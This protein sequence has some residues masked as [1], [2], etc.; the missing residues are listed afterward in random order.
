LNI[1]DLFVLLVLGI[2]T[3]I[4][5]YNGSIVSAINAA[6]FVLSWL[7]SLIFYPLIS[8]LIISK[9]PSLFTLVKFYADGSSKIPN[10]ENRAMQVT[11]FTKESVGQIVTDSQIP[12]PFGRILVSAFSKSDTSLTLAEYFDTT[13][14]TVIINI[15][16]L[17]LLFVLIRILV[18]I[19]A[20][21]YKTVKEIPVLKKFDSLT[22]AG[23]GLLRGMLVANFIFALVPILTTI[24]PIEFVNNLIEESLLGNLF[25]KINI[26][27]VFIRG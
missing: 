14:A 19:A 27:T 1:I 17:L 23:I 2:Y 3:T 15:F 20:S 16:S 6:S 5:A 26:F 25:Y 12:N 18:M 4:G 8:K 7:V 9:I 10:V 21:I 13:I 24:A 22:G 11:R